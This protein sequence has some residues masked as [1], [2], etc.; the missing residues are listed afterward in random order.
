MISSPS[1]TFIHVPRTGGWSIT[2]ALRGVTTSNNKHHHS[3]LGDTNGVWSFG[4]VRNPWDRLVSLWSSRWNPHRLPFEE[5]LSDDSLKK[6]FPNVAPLSASYWLKN[7]TREV[8][9]IYK[10]EDLE[11]AWQDIC[12]RL[13]LK[14]QPLPHRH[15]LTRPPSFEIHTPQTMEVIREA[16]HWE[17]TKFGYSVPS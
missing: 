9:T 6:K 2:H 3:P 17:V 5:W 11:D 14:P 12:K 13:G 10:F 4:V 15:K 1:F 16:C 8:D 7:G